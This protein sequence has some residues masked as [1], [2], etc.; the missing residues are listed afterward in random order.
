MG[1]VFSVAQVW[2][3]NVPR[4]PWCRK[5]RNRNSAVRWFNVCKQPTCCIYRQVEAA[6]TSPSS[7]TTP[8]GYM[9]DTLSEENKQ[10]CWEL[11]P[12]YGGSTLSDKT[13][14]SCCRFCCLNTDTRLVVICGHLS[15]N[16][17]SNGLILCCVWYLR[18]IWKEYFHICC[19][20]TSAAKGPKWMENWIGLMTVICGDPAQ[21]NHKLTWGGGSR[22]C[23]RGPNCSYISSVSSVSWGSVGVN[24][25]VLCPSC[26]AP[27]EVWHLSLVW[28]PDCPANS[29]SD[30]NNWSGAM[31]HTPE[32]LGGNNQTGPENN[33]GPHPCPSPRAPAPTLRQTLQSAQAQLLKKL[34]CP[35]VCQSEPKGTPCNCCC[36]LSNDRRNSVKGQRAFCRWFSCTTLFCVLSSSSSLRSSVLPGWRSVDEA[37]LF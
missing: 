29:K 34:I 16:P 37:S 35:P 7:Q 9:H 4:K 15:L 22:V 21:I 17:H 13:W 23:L 36:F 12:P 2:P 31:P 8:T 24:Q 26:R 32:C 19:K 1:E 11:C 28:R 18:N 6:S 27:E 10:T 3:R 5:L 30:E 25:K 33:P 14:M 20:R